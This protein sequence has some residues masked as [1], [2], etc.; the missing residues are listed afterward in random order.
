MS[1]RLVFGGICFLFLASFI[2]PFQ[3]TGGFFKP[4]HL[5]GIA[6]LYLVIGLLFFR[7][8]RLSENIKL[9]ALGTLLAALPLVSFFVIWL[10][11]GAP[12]L[13]AI[14][15][16]N[17]AFL[18]FLCFL[19]LGTRG[20]LPSISD[21]KRLNEQINVFI[22]LLAIA[23]IA[24][25]NVPGSV[26]QGQLSLFGFPIP[27]RLINGG[28]LQ[29]NVFASG[30]LSILALS[31]W[32][33]SEISERISLV[34][35]GS[36]AVIVGQ[37]LL[38]GSRTGFLI[39]F[40][41]FLWL[42]VFVRQRDKRSLLYQFIFACL[43]GWFFSLIGSEALNGR[44]V[45]A[46]VSGLISGDDATNHR[47]SL[48]HGA[49]LIG[50]ERPLL[51]WGLG[52]FNFVYQDLYQSSTETLFPF[53]AGYHHPHNEFLNLW[54]M[55]GA[56]GVLGVL[57]PIVL[58]IIAVCR[59]RLFSFVLF[60]P[61]AVHSNTEY[62]LYGSSFHLIVL[63]VALYLI[64]MSDDDRSWFDKKLIRFPRS[65]SVVIGISAFVLS[66]VIYESAL[67]SHVAGRNLGSFANKSYNLE[68]YISARQG[69]K[70]L[71]HWLIGEKERLRYFLNQAEIAMALG[72][73]DKVRELLPQIKGFVRV[74]SSQPNWARLAAAYNGLGMRDHLVGF[75]AYLDNLDPAY[76]DELRKYYRVN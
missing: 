25:T 35:V 43:L 54:V 16:L 38:L 21:P 56:V 6:A 8:F 67:A 28:F 53:A 40:L 23:L 55:G 59:K 75:L 27:L 44:D 20:L 19:C 72:Q 73:T 60:I 29:P 48:W 45:A 18:L 70:E 15:Y 39:L 42:L 1:L 26:D 30:L 36:W 74:S 10:V 64:V 7:A 24:W 4:G 41:I 14:P 50:F 47:L 5:A 62:P 32:L 12:F 61:L 2:P 58:L 69:H 17:F 57:G 49:L 52:S 46:R 11:S 31:I 34:L 68:S 33:R 63:V 76:A 22:N 3:H 71:E 9:P 65:N 37:L 51:G 66:M 13:T